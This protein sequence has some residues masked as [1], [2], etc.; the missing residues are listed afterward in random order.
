MNIQ[1]PAAQCKCHHAHDPPLVRSHTSHNPCIPSKTPSDV[2]LPGLDLPE[3]I[4]IPWQETRSTWRCCC[5][6]DLGTVRTSTR[7]DA[8]PIPQGKLLTAR[9]HLISDHG[10]D[11]NQPDSFVLEKRWRRKELLPRLSLLLGSTSSPAEVHSNHR[12]GTF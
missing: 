12:E 2:R 9:A 1:H 4:H 5:R 10:L 7:P 6:F 11:S 8:C 3:R